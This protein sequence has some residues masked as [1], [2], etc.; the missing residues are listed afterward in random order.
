ML[1]K[2]IK[3]RS[4]TMKKKAPLLYTFLFLALALFLFVGCKDD[5]ATDSKDNTT[6]S[7]TPVQCTVGDDS[8]CELWQR[9]HQGHCV[10]ERLC[11]TNNDCPAG[12]VCKGGTCAPSSRCE[13]GCPP[14]EFVCVAAGDGGCQLGCFDDNDCSG[15]RVCGGHDTTTGLG[16][17]RNP[18]PGPVLCTVGD[19]S[20]CELWQRCLEGHCVGERQCETND[21]CS[22]G[23]TCKGGICAPSSECKVGCQ[24][25]SACA[26]PATGCQPGCLVDKDCSGSRIC[27]GHDTTTGLGT[28]RNPTQ[29]PPL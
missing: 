17:C 19:D 2:A 25:E 16:T 24:T 4:P 15:G 11:E 3:T 14:G 9:C 6:D 13:V 12:R 7:P 26:S 20:P 29:R 8:P 28:C 5:K 22:G 10:G 21:K 27:G 1:L 18:T 23:K